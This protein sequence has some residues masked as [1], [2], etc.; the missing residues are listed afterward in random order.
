MKTTKKEKIERFDAVEAERSNLSLAI[1]DLVN[2]KFSKPVIVKEKNYGTPAYVAGGV[3]SL[4]VS[5]RA[6][7]IFLSEFRD[8]HNNPNSRVSPRVWTESELEDISRDSYSTA[9]CMLRDAFYECK[10]L[11]YPKA[12]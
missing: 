6:M 11:Y 4:R 2:D 1:Y 5:M 7:P 8:L 3:L 10:R 9:D 12:A